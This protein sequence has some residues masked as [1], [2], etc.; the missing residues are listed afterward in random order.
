MYSSIWLSNNNFNVKTLKADTYDNALEHLSSRCDWLKIPLN[1]FFLLLF[2]RQSSAENAQII[3]L[4]VHPSSFCR[5]FSRVVDFQC[6]WPLTV[7]DWCPCSSPGAVPSAT[8]HHYKH[9]PNGTPP[10]KLATVFFFVSP[11]LLSLAHSWFHFTRKAG[12]F[13]FLL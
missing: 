3:H 13:F 4:R 10:W 12:F 1:D 7:A 11:S 5:H 8:N 2:F 6:V 9:S